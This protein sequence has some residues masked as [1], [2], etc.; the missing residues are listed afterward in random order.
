M[1]VKICLSS[2]PALVY[3]HFV[4]ENVQRFIFCGV[5]VN[6]ADDIDRTI[7]E[8]INNENFGISRLELTEISIEKT[9][10]NHV[11]FC[12][13]YMESIKTFHIDIIFLNDVLGYC[14]KNG[15]AIEVLELS[16][17]TFVLC[18]IDNYD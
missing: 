16:D 18:E 13:R 7:L 11:W 1:I 15:V 4:E 17:G 9:N 3:G 14:A 12:G 8:S 5:K 6:N 2:Y 10:E